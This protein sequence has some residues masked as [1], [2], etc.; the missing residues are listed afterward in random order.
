MDACANPSIIRQF[1][2]NEPIFIRPFSYDINTPKQ[3][4]EHDLYKAKASWVTNKQSFTL[5]YGYQINKRQEFDVRR[6]NDL[7]IPN[8]NLE[9][10]NESLDAEWVHPSIGILSGRIGAHWSEQTNDNIPGTNTIPFI[11][12]YIV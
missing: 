4:V 2:A 9:L 1:M 11:P 5:Q 7:E 3:G 8:I 12:N 6:G 10:I